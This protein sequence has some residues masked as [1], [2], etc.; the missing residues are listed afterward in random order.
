MS[1][2]NSGIQISGG[3]VHAGAMAAG[4]HAVASSNVSTSG[5]AAQ[6][7]A[8]LRRS[9]ADLAEQV[10]ARA[11]DLDDP[12]QAAAVADLAKAEAEK[13]KPNHRSLLGLLQTLS[14]A[15]GSV[16]TLGGSVNAIIQTVSA[17]ASA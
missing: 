10:R 14:A 11:A 7:L 17:L 8:E 5:D 6:A 13:E 16:A 12:E 1:G 4:N 15:V 9:L 2:R 3:T